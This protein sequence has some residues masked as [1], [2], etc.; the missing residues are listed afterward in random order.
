[1]NERILTPYV[2]QSYFIEN[3][4][5]KAFAIEI[6]DKFL[7]ETGIPGTAGMVSV[8]RYNT[9]GEDVYFS[10]LVF[11]K[12]EVEQLLRTGPR[13]DCE[14]GRPPSA[15]IFDSNVWD[16]AV[17]DHACP[18]DSAHN[19]PPASGQEARAVEVQANAPSNVQA[20]MSAG[21]HRK[22]KDIPEHLKGRAPTKKEMLNLKEMHGW[23]YQDIGDAFHP[24]AKQGARKMWGYRQTTAAIKERAER[25]PKK[26]RM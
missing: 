9:T 25:S 16:S 15:L 13:P 7:S 14:I 20:E 11:D 4:R 6:K 17:Q 5:T 24:N 21:G 19:Q 8:H 3:D 1:M 18:A 12:I 2:V 23:S 22:P 10:S 26:G